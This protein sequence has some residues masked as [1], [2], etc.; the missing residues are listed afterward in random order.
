[1][2]GLVVKKNLEWRTPGFESRSSELKID[3]L[4]I[5]IENS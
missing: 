2:L 4:Q 3:N 5:V 1:M